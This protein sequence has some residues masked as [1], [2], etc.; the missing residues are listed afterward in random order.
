MLKKAVIAL[1][2]ATLVSVV[3][4]AASAGYYCYGYDAFGERCAVIDFG[5]LRSPRWD[6][7]DNYPYFV[8]F[9]SG[10]P[11]LTFGNAP[12]GCYLIRRPVLTPSGWRTRT[13]QLCD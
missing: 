13:V 9:Y 10:T 5:S 1:V 4:Q 6:Y 8:T 11:Y 2:A 12:G 7:S 3:P